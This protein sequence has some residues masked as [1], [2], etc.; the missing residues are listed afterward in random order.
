[1][2]RRLNV[3]SNPEGGWIA[4]LWL[5]SILA[6]CEPS[7]T[8][9]ETHAR[10]FIEAL[11]I[12]P[13]EME[14]LR[15]ISNLSSERHPEELLDDLSARVG[16]DYLRTMQVQ[17]ESLKFVLGESRRL[18]ETQRTVKVHVTYLQPGATSMG[19]VR[20]LVRIDVSGLNRWH[21][22]RVTG[23]N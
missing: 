15:D 2:D 8:V 11:V 10:D 14:Q 19:E 20:F 16:L 23:D 12:S 7:W 17:G 22:V 3:R 6:A 9:Q 5:V 1:M 13:S 21:I 18:G 4:G